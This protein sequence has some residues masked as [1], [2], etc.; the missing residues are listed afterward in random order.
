MGNA[1]H[2]TLPASL[3]AAGEPG[4]NAGPMLPPLVAGWVSFLAE[5]LAAEYLRETESEPDAA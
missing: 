2:R 4:K 5:L 1:T 3:D